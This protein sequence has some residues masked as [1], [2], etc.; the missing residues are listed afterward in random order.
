MSNAKA[1]PFALG[2][3]ISK[4]V[5]YVSG[6]NIEASSLVANHIVYNPSGR[7]TI[8]N[9]FTVPILTLDYVVKRLNQVIGKAIAHIDLAK[10]DVE[11][12]EMHVLRGAEK[13]LGKGIIEHF[14]IEVHKDQV[15]T[16]KLVEYLKRFGY[17]VDK[18][19]GFNHVKDVAYLKLRR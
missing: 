12:Y 14:V 17:G 7:Y 18:V 3:R 8:I 13:T 19:V 15:S 16:E 4:A 10:I 6:E 5:L 11:G 9:T 2:D 1:L